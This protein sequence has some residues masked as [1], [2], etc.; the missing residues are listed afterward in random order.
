MNWTALIAAGVVAALTLGPIPARAADTQQT[1]DKPQTGDKHRKAEQQRSTIRP[2]HWGQRGS[3]RMLEDRVFLRLAERAWAGADFKVAAR[4]DTVTIS[5]TV[6]TQE[7]K[8]RVLRV[9]RTTPGVVDVRDQLKIDA[10][11]AR[12]AQPATSVNDPELSKR[13]AQKVGGAISGARA[14]E[15]WWFT[16]WR[17]EGPDN[18]WNLVVEAENGQITLEGD[19][20]RTGIARQAVVTALQVPGVRSV[21]SELDVSPMFG[22]YDAEYDRYE[23]YPPYGAYPYGYPHGP[24][25]YRR[26]YGWR[27]RDTFDAH[28][29]RGLHTMTG[30]VTAIDQKTGMVS[31]KTP[32]GTL[33]LHFPPAALQGVKQ[34][35]RITIELGLREPGQAS[36]SPETGQGSSPRR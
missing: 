15:D 1:G 26:D 14:G 22:R 6:P 34:G 18:R 27:D 4:G 17:V 7:A 30:E 35:E 11:A 16:G 10:S 23:R 20:P 36:A 25:A 3:G 32:E 8:Q 24:S 5:G 2:E 19:V 12:A 31:L 29:F 33:Q 13:V 21:R 28:G 9:V